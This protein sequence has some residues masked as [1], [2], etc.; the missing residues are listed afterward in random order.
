MSLPDPSL[1]QVII[2][3]SDI[4]RKIHTKKK[5]HEILQNSL[6][7]V[8]N[9]CWYNIFETYVGCWGCSL[10]D[11]YIM[12]ICQCSGKITGFTK[13]GLISSQC[14]CCWCYCII[15]EKN[16]KIAVSFKTF[17]KSVQIRL[18]SSK[19]CPANSHVLP[20]I[21]QQNLPQNF[22]WI[23]HDI[24]C[25]STYRYLFLKI[26]WNLSDFFSAT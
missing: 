8:S 6:E 20:I 2:R 21:F 25:F 10:P 16:G 3:A 7:I 22:L 19:I 12:K 18:L 17:V 11:W 13:T 24:G 5:S 1:E 26:P 9:T 14:F 15:S 23:S 4:S